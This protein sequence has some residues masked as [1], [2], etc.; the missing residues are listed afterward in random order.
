MTDGCEVG[1]RTVGKAKGLDVGTTDGGFVSMIF[2]GSLVGPPVGLTEGIGVGAE[3]VLYWENSLD[4][5][6]S[7]NTLQAG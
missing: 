2:V 1:A 3:L 5:R 6:L 4:S 7:G